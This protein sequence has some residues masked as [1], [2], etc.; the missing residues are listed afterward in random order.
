[1]KDLVLEFVFSDE[2]VNR[3]K[4][5]VRTEGIRTDAYMQNPVFLIHHDDYTAAIGKVIEL[6]K[7]GGKLHG[8]VQFDS[9]DPEA[10]K[11]YNKYKNGYMKAVSISF[12]D[13]TT[14]DAEEYIK[15]GQKYATI[16]ECEL[17][18]ISAVNIPGNRNALKLYGDKGEELQ[19]SFITLNNNTVMDEE[20]KKTLESKIEKL[21]S[22]NITL[23]GTVESLT[24]EKETLTKKVETLKTEKEVLATRLDDHNKEQSKT[25]V[26]THTKRGAILEMQRDTYEKKASEDYENTK[27]ELE[28]LPSR[29][30]FFVKGSEQDK[31]QTALEREIAKLETPTT[32]K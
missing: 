5:W 18:E 31:Q 4:Y 23:T 25:L 27:K 11:I 10:V 32:L 24:T 3:Y 20:T 28:A 9:D 19:L 8:K 13:I 14:T 12:G 6:K 30:K 26:D 16:Y 7:T 29:P 17:L 22:E 1:M 21:E 2:S 15:P